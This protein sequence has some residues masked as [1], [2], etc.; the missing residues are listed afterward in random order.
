LKLPITPAAA[1]SRASAILSDRQ[2]ANDSRVLGY[3]PTRS[4]F[5][6][7]R[8]S[9]AKIGI[10]MMP[11]PKRF[12]P[13]DSAV[14]RYVLTDGRIEMCWPCRI[15]EDTD[16]LVALFIAAG[17]KY[18]AGQKR[19]AAQKRATPLPAL[20]AGEYVWRTDTLRLM[21][22]GKQHSV[23]LIWVDTD[24]GRQFSKYFVNM[25]EPFRRTPVG[26]DTQDHTLD[27]VVQPDLTWAWRDRE[28][29]ENHVREGFFT[30][31]LA[32][33]VRREG[34]TVID[35]IRRG[36]HPCSFGWSEWQPGKDWETPVVSKGWDSTPPTFWDRRLWAYGAGD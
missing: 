31:N 36:A 28:E 15:V 23:S 24:T 21:F 13:G 9:G 22:P 30:T 25:E 33:S 26:F 10:A 18:K 8:P 12:Q 35:E 27:I 17:S 29:L 20:P 2:A 5:G 34:L 4:S 14:L 32:Q 6:S 3:T 16:D 1:P 19:T 11:T 7:K